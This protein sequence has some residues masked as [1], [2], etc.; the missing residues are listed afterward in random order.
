MK[1]SGTKVPSLQLKVVTEGT[2]PSK[3][4]AV[5]VPPLPTRNRSVEVSH[6]A[7][8]MCA[9]KS[10][11]MTTPSK[12]CVTWCITCKV[13]VRR[14]RARDVRYTPCC[15]VRSFKDGRGIFMP[16]HQ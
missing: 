2:K 3:Q 11:V 8:A 5:H 10:R 16:I 6:D 7:S 4:F 1:V 13:F 9:K 15:V 12:L 14:A